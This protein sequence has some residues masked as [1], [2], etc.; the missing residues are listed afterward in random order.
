MVEQLRKEAATL[1]SA[2]RLCAGLEWLYRKDFQ[3]I[4]TDRWKDQFKVSFETARKDLTWLAE[5]GYLTIRI[6]G[7]KKYFDL[8]RK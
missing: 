2:D 7:H 6:S 5:K 8:I 1:A 4:T 3:S